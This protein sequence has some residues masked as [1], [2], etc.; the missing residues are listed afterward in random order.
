MR[1][2]ALVSLR[3]IATLRGSGYLF[4]HPP[5]TRIEA[6]PMSDQLVIA[7]RAF[8]SRLIVGTGKYRSFQEMARAHAA[9]GAEMVTVAVGRVNLTDKS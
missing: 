2:A 7:G 6:T 5:W 4:C 1:G 3:A 9:C 8:N